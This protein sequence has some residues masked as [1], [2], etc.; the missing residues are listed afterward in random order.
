MAKLLNRLRRNSF[1]VLLITFGLISIVILFVMPSVQTGQLLNA[2]STTK[3]PV[4]RT[5]PEKELIELKNEIRKTWAQIL[6]GS[7]FFITAYLTW[8]NLREADEANITDRFTKAIDQLDGNKPPMVRLGAIYALIRIAKDS[9]D[10]RQAVAEILTEYI[11]QRMPSYPSSAT[12]TFTELVKGISNTDETSLQTDL[13]PDIQAA[14]R[15]FKTDVGYSP[16]FDG[17]DL[18]GVIFSDLHLENAT[19]I[20]TCLEDVQM[21]SANL[22]GANF[23]GAHLS[24]AHLE[25]ANLR[26]A[27]LVDAVL[28]KA[29]LNNA[30]LNEA[31]L[32][33]A[34]A[35]GAH[36]YSANLHDARLNSADLQEAKLRGAFIKGS[37]W[38]ATKLEG[39]DLSHAWGKSK[40]DIVAE[41]ATSSDKITFTPPSLRKHVVNLVLYMI[42]L[43]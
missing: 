5:L 36:L 25:G 39:A 37:I 20:G 9:D 3:T 40:E 1:L 8:Q 22:K 12:A 13:P 19:F 4:T 38:R 24:G 41:S 15:I 26:F 16:R 6:T 42:S 23:R 33:Q 17:L 27:D 14:L 21:Q 7:F 28:E 30:N 2:T 31:V 10:D 29:F 18:R 11:R 43:K 35:K 32:T 34:K